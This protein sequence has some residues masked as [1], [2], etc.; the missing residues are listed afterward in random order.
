MVN[1]ANWND[2]ERVEIKVHP[3]DFRRTFDGDNTRITI[4][5]VQPDP[6]NPNPHS[7]AHEQFNW[8]VEGEGVVYLDGEEIEMKAGDIIQIP[9]NVTHCFQPS[10]DKKITMVEIFSPIPKV[11]GSK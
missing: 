10:G 11:M 5:D 1:K 9:P 7:H 3:G 6:G 8:V 4:S 2:I